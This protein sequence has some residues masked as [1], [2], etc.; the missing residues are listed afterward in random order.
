M[1]ASNCIKTNLKATLIKA[2]RN[3]CDQRV[4]TITAIEQIRATYVIESV[5]ASA[6]VDF[7]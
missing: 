2:S 3:I 7:V 6:T 1:C 5:I 4:T